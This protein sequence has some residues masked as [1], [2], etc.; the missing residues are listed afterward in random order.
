MSTDPYGKYYKE[1]KQIE[2]M[3][4]GLT[5]DLMM[6]EESLAESQHTQACSTLLKIAGDIEEVVNLIKST[7]SILLIPEVIVELKDIT[8]FTQKFETLV[9]GRSWFSI[10]SEFEPKDSLDNIKSLSSILKRSNKKPKR[11][12]NETGSD[13]G[14][15]LGRGLAGKNDNL[16]D[17]DMFAKYQQKVSMRGVRE[18]EDDR[19][20]INDLKERIETRRLQNKFDDR[21]LYG[22]EL[23]V[24]NLWR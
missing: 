10:C 11:V 18:K 20:K 7:K 6:L 5:W 12:R 9:R 23:D 1:V 2:G 13:S 19:K 3:K 4:S 15:V 24:K 14:P 17:D 8:E 16:V 22:K 21:F